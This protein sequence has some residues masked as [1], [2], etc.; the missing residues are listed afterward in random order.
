MLTNWYIKNIIIPNFVKYD[1][2]GFVII[3]QNTKSGNI[4]QRDIFLSEELLSRL[5]TE[6][7]ATYGEKGK[8]FLYKIGKNFGWDYGKAFKIPTL[9]TSKVGDVKQ[10]AIFLSKFIGG[11]WAQRSDIIKLDME[12]NYFEITFEDY[13]VCR[14]NG[15]GY[16]LNS[17][18]ICG[19]WAWMLGDFNL[20]GV[21]TKCQGRKDSECKTI[22]APLTT[23]SKIS[24]E[25]YMMPDL[26]ETNSLSEDYRIYNKIRPPMFSTST[27]KELITSN[28]L[29]YK[30]GIVEYH[31]ERYLPMRIE[32]LFLLES[33][34]GY[35]Q[36]GD[37]FLFQVAFDVGTRIA[38]KEKYMST[39]FISDF[40]SFQG[41]GDMLITTDLSRISIQYYPWHELY[42][43]TKKDVFLGLLS[44]FIS[45]Y[46]NKRITVEIKDEDL[47]KGFVSMNFIIK[48]QS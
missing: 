31:D 15:L 28:V 18:S 42:A 3:E 47:K 23:L 25:S 43:K 46:K 40:M 37:K 32:F 13:V 17:G 11:M 30:N 26:I 21:Q 24:N 7:T 14:H 44:A 41:W 35:L 12:N 5:E 16:L 33:Q 20:E 2:P 29:T 4:Y 10:A 19:L 39:K 38:K 1:N 22:C 27:V 34:I 45:V 6:I 9:K 8:V 48:E 36:D